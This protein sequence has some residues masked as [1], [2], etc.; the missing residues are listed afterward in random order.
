MIETIRKRFDETVGVLRLTEEHLSGR[1][2]QAADLLV[3][4]FRNG[5]G[6]LVFGNGGSAADA[7][8]I[9]GELV[10]RFLLERRGLRAEALSTDTS[11]LT[12]LAND[13]D[14]ERVFARQIQAKGRSGDVALGITTSGNSANVVAALRAA[15]ECGMKT[16][17]LTGGGGGK[18]A[19]LA[20][21]LLDIPCN[22]ATPRVQ[23]AHTLVYHIL[24][25]LVEAAIAADER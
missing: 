10:G 16:I 23:E 4:A 22:G 20:D 6:V 17:A 2:A 15:R 12:S 24:C 3:H 7:Q 5:G 11:V 18:C 9:A 1:I 13:Y 14:Y 21:V 8:H 19:L 25:E